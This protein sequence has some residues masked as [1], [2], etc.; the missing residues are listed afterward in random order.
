[1]D[2]QYIEPEEKAASAKLVKTVL[3]GIGIALAISVVMCVISLVLLVRTVSLANR[4]YE[5]NEELNRR[6]ELF[7][8]KIAGV[9]STIEKADKNIENN[10]LVMTTTIDGQSRFVNELYQNMLSR[11]YAD[12]EQKNE[13]ADEAGT[14]D[15]AK[16]A[17]TTKAADDSQEQLLE[18]KAGEG[19]E[20]KEDKAANDSTSPVDALLEV[21]LKILSEMLNQMQ[22]D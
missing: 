3:Y 10:T 20:V 4:V 19:D 14:A 12:S 7:E 16:E 18:T 17:D 15:T 11:T 5:R 9:E 8:E 1:M 13:K 6:Y 22:K 21:E 2:E